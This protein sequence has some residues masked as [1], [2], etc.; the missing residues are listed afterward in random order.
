[1]VDI[2]LCRN[3]NAIHPSIHSFSAADLGLVLSGN[4]VKQL[5]CLPSQPHTRALALLHILQWDMKSIQCFL[6]YPLGLLLV[7]ICL[8]NLC[9]EGLERH[10]L[11]MTEPPSGWYKQCTNGFCTDSFEFLSSSPLS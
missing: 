7:L 5:R 4:G 1:M 2:N 9:M 10:P 8:E 11:Y 3:D 6:G